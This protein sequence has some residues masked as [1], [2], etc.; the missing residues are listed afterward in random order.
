[1]H[2][3]EID[4]D[5]DILID[6]NVPRTLEPVKV[7]PSESGG[8]YAIRTILGWTVNEPLLADGSECAQPTVT[9]NHIS[10]TRLEDLW[11]QQFQVDFPECSQGEKLG[12]SKEKNCG[13]QFSTVQWSLQHCF[14]T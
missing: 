14:A 9:A 3:P 13:K 12:P 6:L 4:S 11:K 5:V 7:I 10:V 1:M 2:L 8:P